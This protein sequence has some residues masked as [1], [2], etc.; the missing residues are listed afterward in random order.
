MKIEWK[1]YL[2]LAIATA[3]IVTAISVNTWFIVRAIGEID[4]IY[5]LRELEQRVSNV[6]DNAESI[7]AHTKS[8]AD[9]TSSIDEHL[10]PPAEYMARWRR[11]HPPLPAKKE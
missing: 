3:A 4:P 5:E 2:P 7:E 1:S 9:S 10:M 8:T 6:N 11:D